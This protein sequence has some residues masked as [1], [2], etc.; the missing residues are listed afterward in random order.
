MGPRKF[1]GLLGS[2]VDYPVNPLLVVGLY[3][4]NLR[5]VYVFFFR[6][7]KNDYFKA[8]FERVNVV[9]Y[10]HIQQIFFTTGQVRLDGFIEHL[11]KSIN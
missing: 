3:D 11:Q 2:F 8:E 1:H 4:P 6:N 7:P 5:F 10:L 9:I